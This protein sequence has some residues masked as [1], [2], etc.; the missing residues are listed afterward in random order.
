MDEEDFLVVFFSWSEL[1][2]LDLPRLLWPLRYLD[3]LG[4]SHF[5]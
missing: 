4:I 5:L 2:L 3:T 1:L